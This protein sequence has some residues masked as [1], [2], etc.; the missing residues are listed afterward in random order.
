MVENISQKHHS[1]QLNLRASLL[2]VPPQ[3]TEAAMV[4][5]E[6]ALLQAVAPQERPQGEQCSP[7]HQLCLMAGEEGREKWQRV[8]LQGL[9][10]HS[11]VAMKQDRNME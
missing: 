4:L 3:H 10:L 2:K 8:V 11:R 5:N 7:L 9:F 6:V 1:L